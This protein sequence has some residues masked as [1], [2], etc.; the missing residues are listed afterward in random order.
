M[1]EYVYRYPIECWH[2]TYDATAPPVD[3]LVSS[4]DPAPPST[5]ATAAAAAAAA[6]SFFASS[7]RSFAR[8]SY[9]RSARKTKKE[10]TKVPIPQ[11]SFTYSKQNRT[12]TPLRPILETKAGGGDTK[13]MKKKKKNSLEKKKEKSLFEIPSRNP[14]ALV[15]KLFL[16]FFFSF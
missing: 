14:T 16:S 9:S 5:T 10:K 4:A 1:Y 13:T 3:V 2:C 8:R 7:R 11:G 6:A 15:T 12:D